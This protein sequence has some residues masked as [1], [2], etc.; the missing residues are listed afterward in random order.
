MLGVFK[1]ALHFV[2]EVGDLVR[3]V[4][5]DVGQF[6]EVVRHLYDIIVAQSEERLEFILQTSLLAT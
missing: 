1:H 3:E 6:L 2:A 5:L 4:H